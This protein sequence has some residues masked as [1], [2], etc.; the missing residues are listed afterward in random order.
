[1]SEQPQEKCV[2]LHGCET[3]TLRV[4]G[5]WRVPTVETTLNECNKVN[6]LAIGYQSL[7]IINYQ[8]KTH[9]KCHHNSK[10]IICFV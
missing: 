2:L 4:L 8:E 9:V 7:I 3:E 5:N 10:N 1:M 6:A